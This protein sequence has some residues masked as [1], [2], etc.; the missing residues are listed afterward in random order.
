MPLARSARVALIAPIALN[1]GLAVSF[2]A[3]SAQPGG[4]GGGAGTERSGEPVRGALDTYTDQIDAAGLLDFEATTL[5]GTA[6]DAATYANR[7]LAVWFW[8]PW[9]P[10]CNGEAPEVVRAAREHPEIQFIGLAGRD[11]QGPMRDFVERYGIDFP[12]VVDRDG[13]IWRRFGVSGQPAWVF[14][15]G[16]GEAWRVLGAPNE[17]E[18]LRILGELTT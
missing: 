1:V 16:R 11:D 13:S 5:D 6:I 7:A 2:A 9:C 3:C 4:S 12:T 14:F 15:N 8:A 10:T 18:F 17:S